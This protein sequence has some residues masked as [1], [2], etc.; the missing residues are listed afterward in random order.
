VPRSSAEMIWRNLTSILGWKMVFLLDPTWT[1]V[2][3]KFFGWEFDVELSGSAWVLAY[4]FFARSLLRTT[5]WL[6]VQLVGLP[7][8][9]I[10]FGP[11]LCHAN[12]LP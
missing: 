1:Q 4:S 7:L 5:L 8:F 10:G 3:P 2:C 11:F 12:S 6:L 9:L